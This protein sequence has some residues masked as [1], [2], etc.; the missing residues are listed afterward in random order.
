MYYKC[1]YFC[2]NTLKLIPFF[3]GRRRPSGHHIPG[4]S[5]SRR[6]VGS[7]FWCCKKPSWAESSPFYFNSATLFPGLGFR[8]AELPRS[9]CIDCVFRIFGCFSVFAVTFLVP[10][11][12]FVRAKTNDELAGVFVMSPIL[13]W[14][15]RSIF[16]VMSSRPTGT[17][18]IDTVRWVVR[19]NLIERTPPSPPR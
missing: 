3:G 18:S 11:T 6:G 7:G 5:V 12:G 17:W 16:V 1:C 13:L 2:F 14:A 15:P 19:L 4:C 9:L 8:S 10:S